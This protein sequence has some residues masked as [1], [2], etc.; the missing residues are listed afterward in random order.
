MTAIP[1]IAPLRDPAWLASF[2]DKDCLARGYGFCDGDVVGH[3]VK[4]GWYGKGIKPGDDTCL[5]LCD[6][7]HRQLHSMPEAEF[8][9]TV[10]NEVPGALAEVL[11]GAAR[12]MW[13]EG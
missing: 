3:H 8:W 11:N 1:K 6:R 9:I 5:P 2:K 7:H 12:L 10:F 13:S 4:L